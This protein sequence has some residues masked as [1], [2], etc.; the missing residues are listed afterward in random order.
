[1][2]DV[3]ATAHSNSRGTMISIVAVVCSLVAPG[4][5]HLAIHADTRRARVLI[6]TFAS[7]AATVVVLLVAVTSRSHRDLA[8]VVADRGRFLAVAI[9]LVVLALTR[10]WTALDVAWAARPEHGAWRTSLAATM[11][12]SLVAVGVTP[13]VVAA[14]YVRRT[15]RAIDNVF[16]SGDSVTAMPGAL[17]TTTLRS[18]GPPATFV[19]STTSSTLAPFPGEDRVNVLLLGGDAGEGRYSL[20]TDTMVVVSIDPATGDTAMISVPRNL[21]KLPFPPDTPLGKRYPR[22]FNDLANAV[23]TVVDRHRDWAGGGEDAGA[24]AIKQGIAQLLGIPIQY[25]VLVDMEG[26]IDVVDA[27]GGITVN[28][29]KR[30]PAPGNPQ[31]AKHLVPLWFEV[32]RQHM[33]GTVALAYARSR[34]ADSDYERMDRQRC[35]LA[36]IAGAA[37][38]WVLAIGL[39]NLVDAFGDSVRTDIPRERLGEIVQLVERFASAGGLD[40]VDTLVL[41]PPLIQPS[42]WKAERVR[43]LVAALLA[44]GAAPTPTDVDA[45]DTTTTGTPTATSTPPGSP[46]EVLAADCT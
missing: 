32:G 33:D 9:A 12:L 15:D 6:P 45:G 44:P 2:M 8:E 29:T 18:H 13:L 14:D 10:L 34:K 17:P 36:G 30:V 27:L 38:P 39:G 31:E 43:E 16:G 4:S 3:M 24:Q 46:G 35:V 23:Y 20:R 1:M 21:K 25:Y 41:A 22:G 26:F 40:S 28:V 5:G 19:A 42:R 37:S 11:S 7:I